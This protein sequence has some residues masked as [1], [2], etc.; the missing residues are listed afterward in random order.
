MCI[1][2]GFPTT[3]ILNQ[4]NPIARIDTYFFRVHSNMVLPSTPRPEE[5]VWKQHY[6]NVNGSRTY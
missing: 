2:M 6:G 1:H 3:P 5:G 4:I